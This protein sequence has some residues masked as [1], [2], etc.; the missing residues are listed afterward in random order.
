MWSWIQTS[1]SPA[2]SAA[3]TQASSTS[4]AD[5]GPMLRTAMPSSIG[6]EEGRARRVLRELFGRERHR[7]LLGSRPHARGERLELREV[8]AIEPG[9]VLAEDRARLGAVHVVEGAAQRLPRVG[10]GALV[11]RVV[12]APQE[13]LHADLVAPR[14][15]PRRGRARALQTLSL[16]L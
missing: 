1:A 10:V 12:A 2:A 8:E 11:V 13:A 15:L 3:R 4:G 6:L 5:S 9:R 7:D 16:L 14:E